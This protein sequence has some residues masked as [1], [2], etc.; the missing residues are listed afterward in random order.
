VDTTSA[1]ALIQEEEL[2]N[3]K[4]KPLNKRFF[5]YV[6]KGPQEKETTNK[7]RPDQEDK[8]STLKQHRRKHGL[9]FKCGGKW[10]IT[11]KCPEQIPLHVLEELWD[12]VGLSS[13]D[14][15]PAQCEDQ[16]TDEVI[17]AVQT[18]NKQKASQRQSLKLLARIGKQQVLVLVDSGSIGTFISE[19]LVQDLNIAPTQCESVTFKAANGSPLPCSRCVPELQWWVDGQ[20]FTSEAKILPLKCYDMIVGEDWLEVVSPVWVDF[21]TKEMRVTVKGKRVTLHGLQEQHKKCSPIGPKKLLKLLKHGAVL[22]CL[23]ITSADQEPSGLDS[24]QNELASVQE[25]DAAD[26]PSLVLQLMNQF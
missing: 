17:C 12:V 18:P 19:K 6:D 14:S 11:H 3:M 24:I 8:L 25:D 22:S 26:I 1:L 7:P 5:R 13:E 2:E 23:Q 20:K 16:E 21:K 15:N 10:S 4:N 9:C